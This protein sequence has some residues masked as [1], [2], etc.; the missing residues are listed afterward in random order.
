M[1][2]M[3]IKADGPVC[4][5]GHKAKHVSQVPGCP[6]SLVYPTPPYRHGSK[7]EERQ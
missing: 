5:T 3:L 2:S 4:D 1:P 6:S 7:H